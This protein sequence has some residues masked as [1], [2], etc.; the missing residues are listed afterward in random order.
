MAL[1]PETLFHQ[2]A[3][4][5]FQA[6]IHIRYNVHTPCDNHAA[7]FAEYRGYQKLCFLEHLVILRKEN[8]KIAASKFHT[9]H[10]VIPSLVSSII[11]GPVAPHRM[12]MGHTPYNDAG[13]GGIFKPDAGAIYPD[14]IV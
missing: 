9:I 3:P 12:R 13:L 5:D 6:P 1:L 4:A 10:S 8:I 11:P 14:I 2:P 7:G